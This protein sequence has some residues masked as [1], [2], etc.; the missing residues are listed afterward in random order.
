MGFWSG[1]F[2]AEAMSVRVNVPTCDR[3]W[4]LNAAFWVAMEHGKQI[5]FDRLIITRFIICS[6]LSG[7]CSFQALILLS[8]STPHIFFCLI[9][10]HLQVLRVHHFHC[11]TEPSR[12][13][14]FHL[15][16]LLQSH[17]PEVEYFDFSVF[18][19]YLFV[20]I[21]DACCWVD[22]CQTY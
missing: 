9:D 14:Y 6:F 5:Q 19:I 7:L 1:A 15:Q 2:H 4:E 12:I 22:T 16:Y 21:F 18:V 11:S 13:L 20:K 8:I 17:E 3:F 10:L